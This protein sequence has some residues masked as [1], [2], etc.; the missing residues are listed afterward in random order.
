[1]KYILLFLLMTVFGCAIDGPG[2]VPCDK[3]IFNV[4]ETDGNH[5]RVDYYNDIQHYVLRVACSP[6]SLTDAAAWKVIKGDDY[7]FG[8]WSF[9]RQCSP[10]WFEVEFYRRVE[11]DSV[12]V[13]DRKRI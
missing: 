7:G 2:A 4:W 1:M 6:D 3:H 13:K 5:I 8:V 12:L 11:E 10:M 9:A